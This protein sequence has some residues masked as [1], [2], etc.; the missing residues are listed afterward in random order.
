MD[1]HFKIV[2]PM[3]N[4]EKW[5]TKTISSLQNQTYQNFSCLV[6]DDNSADK[7][8]EI[9]KDLTKL[10]PRFSIIKNGKR[11]GALY[12]IVNGFKF[13]NPSDED[14]LTTL[15]GDDWLACDD[16]LEY[17]ANVYSTKKCL[18]TY[19]DFTR[20]PSGEYDALGDFPVEIIQNNAYRDYRW[21]SSALRTFKY[22]LWKNIKEEDLKDSRG[23]FYAMAWDLSFM[24]PMLEMSGGNFIHTKKN[25]Y[26]YNRENPINDDKVSTQKQLTLDSIIRNKKRYQ[27]LNKDNYLNNSIHPL[28]LLTA[29]RFD[30]P[31]KTLYARHRSK[32][33][34]CDWSK[35]VYEH[36]L[37]VWGGFREKDRP[38]SNLIDFYSSCHA[39]LDSLSTQGFDPSISKI[40]VNE[41]NLMLNGAHSVS[42]A[43]TF[44]RPV[45]TKLAPPIA[46]QLDCS[47]NY[48]LN[49][50]DIV[51]N[52]LSRS[53]ADVMA[54]E[55]TRLK[56]NTFMASLYPAALPYWKEITRIFYEEEI[57]IIYDKNFNLS[58]HGKINYA[59]SLYYGEAWIGDHTNNFGGAQQQAS[60]NFKQGDGVK[61]VLL[62]A[63]HKDKVQKA[64][65]RIRDLV[66]IGKPSIHTTDT[67]YQAWVNATTAFNDNSLNFINTSPVGGGHDAL[68]SNFI[69]ETKKWI[70]HNEIDV[71]DFCVGGSSILGAYKLRE[72]RDFDL[73]HTFNTATFREPISSHNDYISYYGRNIEDI[74]MDPHNHLFIQGLKI[75]T[76]Q[77]AFDL[78]KNRGEEKDIKDC[79][80]LKP[81]V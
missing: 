16:A 44:N 29:Y 69:Y 54:L 51:K 2:I 3:Y 24:F 79:E 12:N 4:V 28:N 48:F 78:K 33:L 57:S 8:F 72:I 5:V 60:L 21:S 14:V 27:P 34:N 39:F 61:A 38:K 76:P 36:H 80:L 6:V 41:N 50:T 63:S 43:I 74:V 20:Y 19:G 55:Y 75:I 13:L 64:K 77:I 7:G 81:F 45:L 23:S 35:K 62:E 68:F 40:P 15:D 58:P 31:S 66:K 42:A 30:I 70:E 65:D 67:R 17:V 10:D 9:V 26:I 11:Q 18:L 47:S 73:L 46:G 22:Q 59:I 37:N 49:K 71:E 1:I 32:G 56:P 53:M 25:L 52:G